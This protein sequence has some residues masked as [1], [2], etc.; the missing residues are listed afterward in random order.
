MTVLWFFSVAVHISLVVLLFAKRQF[1]RYPAFV[2]FIA[3][4]CSE[5]VTCA[6]LRH[7]PEAYFYAYWVGELL[8]ACAKIWL[9]VELFQSACQT[10]I[11][12]KVAIRRFY[13]VQAFLIGGS[14]ALAVLFPSRYPVAMMAIIRTADTGASLALCLML[15][16]VLVT[17]HIE[18]TFWLRRTFGIGFGLLLYLPIKVA[19]VMLKGAHGPALISSIRWIEVGS[20]LG[21]LI[22][23]T[24]SFL[25]PEAGRTI[26][27]VEAL[28]R[29]ASEL[30][31]LSR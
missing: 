23:W 7:N 17:S 27:S 26:A 20:F 1:Q 19:V 22:L 6:L 3:I 13:V 18:G 11:M 29:R 2:S 14:A 25:R 10:E 30:E 31:G 21:A 4:S 16:A 15:F 24:I 8:C 5:N 9:L 28:E 12:E